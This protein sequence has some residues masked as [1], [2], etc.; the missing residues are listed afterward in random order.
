[1]AL[2]RRIPRAGNASALK[3]SLVSRSKPSENVASGARNN[4]TNSQS[5]GGVASA[6]PSSRSSAVARQTRHFSPPQGQFAS[7]T[8]GTT[9][10]PKVE[11]PED[12]NPSWVKA[13]GFAAAAAATW[14]YIIKIS[15]DAF[16]FPTGMLN[17]N[18]PSPPH[19]HWPNSDFFSSFDH[20]SIRRGYDV[21]RNVCAQCHSL[22]GVAFRHFVGVSHTEAQAKQLAS[23]VMVP[24]GFNEEGEPIKRAGSMLDYMPQPYPNEAAARA[25]NGGALPPDLTKIALTDHHLHDYIFALLT[26][27]NDPPPGVAPQ[28]GKYWN[29]YFDGGWISM[30]PPLVVD[31][32]IEYDDGTPATK[33]QMAKDVTHFLQ[34]AAH[35][36]HDNNKR[37]GTF[38]LSIIGV[39]F[40]V[41]VGARRHRYMGD[42]HAHLRYIKPKP[43]VY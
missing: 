4:S 27:Y 1:M 5:A 25:A 8:L 13:F 41:M 6:S 26:G 30:P 43:K 38:A 11:N 7:E 40:L 24:G 28:D 36:H 20:A 22:N 35:R 21:Y 16:H 42:A 37:F 32:Q 19:Y 17:E 29:T 14:Y 34:W 3:R 10:G 31:E 15:A 12:E 33:S 23:T 2:R 39:W 9:S 18:P